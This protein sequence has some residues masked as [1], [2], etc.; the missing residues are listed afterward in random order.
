MIYFFII[1]IIGNPN[2]DLNK[3]K[4]RNLIE[5]RR[6][7]KDHVMTTMTRTGSLKRAVRRNV[8]AEMRR[9]CENMQPTH[10]ARRNTGM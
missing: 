8:F 1:W 3:T 9:T 10:N 4:Q 2:N 5:K 7:V 6:D